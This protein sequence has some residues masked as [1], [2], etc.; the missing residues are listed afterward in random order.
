MF[1][2][3]K[4]EELPRLRDEIAALR[5]IVLNRLEKHLNELEFELAYQEITPPQRA[6]LERHLARL[7]E[8][9]R[10]IETERSGRRWNEWLALPTRSLAERLLY[11]RE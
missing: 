4:A 7:A 10:R 8:G 2:L 3:R 11:G 9:I 5:S 1:L 6:A